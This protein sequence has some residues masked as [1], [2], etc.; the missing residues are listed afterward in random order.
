MSA[1]ISFYFH[2]VKWELLLLE[3]WLPN[4]A[5]KRKNW[6]SSHQ[7]SIFCLLHRVRQM[8]STKCHSSASISA[9]SREIKRRA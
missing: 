5:V 7:T 4:D 6:N 3:R 9:F 2:D 1:V 8:G